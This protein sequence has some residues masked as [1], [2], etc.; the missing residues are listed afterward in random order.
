MR[1]I[2]KDLRFTYFEEDQVQSLLRT[3]DLS[4]VAVKT[5]AANSVVGCNFL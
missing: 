1:I 5:F 2:D 4:A 3:G